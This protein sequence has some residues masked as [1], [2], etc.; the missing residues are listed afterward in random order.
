MSQERLNLFFTE[1]RIGATCIK[2]SQQKHFT[3]YDLKLDSKTKVSKIKNCLEEIALVLQ[4]MTTPS[5][6]VL[7]QE[8]TIRLQVITKK[9]DSLKL[10]QVWSLGP[11]FLPLTLGE[12]ASG[13][14]LQIDMIDNPHLLISGSTGSGKSVLLHNLI[15]NVLKV[16]Q[17]QLF[18]IDTKR[19]EF[20]HYHRLA[21][22]ANS[23]STS[24][25][26][27]DNLIEIMEQRYKIL[28]QLKLRSV[29][30]APQLFSKIVLIIDELADL[31]LSDQ[32]SQLQ[33]QLI[34][35]AA[36]SRAAGIYLI[37]A[38]QR[39]SVDVVTGLIKANFPGR[40]ALRT[41]SKIDSQVVF[42]APGAE[43]LLGNGDAWFRNPNHVPTRL[44][45]AYC[46]PQ[47]VLDANRI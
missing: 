19:V 13:D 14:K 1:A 45:V 38:T 9:P 33:N 12:S 10:D 39:P 30:E 5:Y 2:V 15:Y 11:G 46:D 6:I 44:Q 35:L 18:L 21:K 28:A 17:T 29:V 7:P 42:D 3:F 22:V 41:A 31:F 37:V 43:C 8:S 24:L 47:M 40:I 27:L 23:Y 20:S 16:P 26:L 34:K 25:I 32:D 36:K 4:A